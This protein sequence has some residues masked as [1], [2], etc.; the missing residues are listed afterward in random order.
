[1]NAKHVESTLHTLRDD[2]RNWLLGQLSPPERELLNDLINR[3]LPQPS[4][5]ENKFE[6]A[7]AKE[8]SSRFDAQLVHQLNRLAPAQIISVLDSEPDWVIGLLLSAHAWTWHQAVLEKLIATRRIP[9]R[10]LGYG[11]TRP[12]AMQAILLQ[13]LLNHAL[14][15][16]TQDS[17]L[18][19]HTSS[20]TSKPR[21]Y[22]W[23]KPLQRIKKWLP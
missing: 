18:P 16:A 23:R 2:D 5:Q 4:T 19:H 14:L 9:A 17:P 22:L 12:H 13:Q 11:M 15:V 3:Q 10:R 8:T 1:M 6:Q 20:T 7:V 21:E